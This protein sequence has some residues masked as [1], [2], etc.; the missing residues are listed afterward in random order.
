MSYLHINMTAM[1]MR[2]RN[3]AESV[4]QLK[5]LPVLQCLHTKPL[6]KPY[7]SWVGKLDS[8]LV[9]DATK[10]HEQA[11][12]EVPPVTRSHR[13]CMDLQVPLASRLSLTC[14]VYSLPTNCT[15]S[16]S[17]TDSN[18]FRLL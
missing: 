10:V 12:S 16:I 13:R 2:L 3:E 8:M 17:L 4:G 7:L 11:L 1:T 9:D 18:K 14:T 15:H 6:L 5:L